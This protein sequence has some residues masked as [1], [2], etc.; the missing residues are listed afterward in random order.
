M[1]YTS[2]FPKTL[3][4]FTISS[5]N[6]HGICVKDKAKSRRKLEAISSLNTDISIII[7]SHVDSSGLEKLYKDNRVL[8]SK[9][10]VVSN[11]AARRGILILFK[12]QT[13]ITLGLSLIHI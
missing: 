5:T 10:N 2:P 11:Y 12:K 4:A 1:S 6:I 7:D 13:G 3:S 8:L 9:Y